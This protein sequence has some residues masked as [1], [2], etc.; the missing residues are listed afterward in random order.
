MFSVSEER[1][2]LGIEVD[3]S[4]SALRVIRALEQIT[5]WRGRAAALRCDNGPEYLSQTLVTWANQHRITLMD[6]QPGKPIQNAYIERF[7]RTS[8]HEWLD[9]HAF[10]SLGHAQSLATQWLW[11]Y[12]NE[13]PNA[14]KATADGSL[15]LYSKERL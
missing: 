11:K 15:T 6:I 4:L 7:N 14:A 1:E 3:F 10:E 12:N 13:R 9:L 2:G 8:R 5:E